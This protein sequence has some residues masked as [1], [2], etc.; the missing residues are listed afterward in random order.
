MS[1]FIQAVTLK[2]NELS[3]NKCTLCPLQSPQKFSMTL[4]SAT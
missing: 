1:V 3:E 4:M 2:G